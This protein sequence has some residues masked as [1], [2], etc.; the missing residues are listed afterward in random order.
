MSF[1]YRLRVSTLRY[2][3]KKLAVTP[4]TV[5]IRNRLTDLEQRRH[6]RST[7][8]LGNHIVNARNILDVTHAVRPHPGR[9]GPGR[10]RGRH[11]FARMAAPIG[12]D[13]RFGASPRGA[14]LE[15]TPTWP[16][17][18]LPRHGTT[19][20]ERGHAPQEY[21]PRTPTPR[22]PSP[23]ASVN[24]ETLLATWPRWRRDTR[25][26]ADARGRTHARTADAFRACHA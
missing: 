6:A 22:Q 21:R 10:E 12:R 23:T 9:S 2:P 19:T 25:T 7:A 26:R 3:D 18:A 4:R 1:L 14:A 15:S 8:S 20:L 13:S 11:P 17:R 24:R 5:A 16:R